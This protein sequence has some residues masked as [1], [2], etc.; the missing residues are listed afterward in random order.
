MDLLY[1]E[2]QRLRLDGSQIGLEPGDDTPWFCTPV[3][4]EIIGWDSGIH[5]CFLPEFGDM[6]FCINPETCCD[7]YV[8]PIAE[9]FRDFLRL[10]LAVGNTNTLQQIIWWD[11]CAFD[12]FLNDPEEREYRSSPEVTQALRTIAE[13]LE[14]TPMEDPFGVV[15]A[16]QSQFPYEKIPFSNDYYDTL[17]LPR[18]D[19][20]E[21]GPSPS[22]FES[23]SFHVERAADQSL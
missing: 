15:K 8:Y 17:G 7:H 1:T 20:T 13:G 12:A 2:F 23:V 11:K 3:G 18:P 9:T 5:Y 4:A 21:A 22:A 16:L 10:I 6:V 14:L 19:G